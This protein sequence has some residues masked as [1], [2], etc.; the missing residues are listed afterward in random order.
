[1]EK[2]LLLW[3]VLNFVQK[4]QLAT[5][6]ILM[7]HSEGEVLILNYYYFL[8]FGHYGHIF[9][10]W[11]MILWGETKLGPILVALKRKR[12]FGS[13]D[14]HF[15]FGSVRTK[16]RAQLFPFRAHPPNCWS[17]S[18]SPLTMLLLLFLLL[19]IVRSGICI[20]FP[21]RLLPSV[22]IHKAHRGGEQFSRRKHVGLLSDLLAFN[23]RHGDRHA[24][25]LRW[26]LGASLRF[27][28][29]R[30]YLVLFPLHHYP[31]PCGH[32]DG[33]FLMSLVSCW[34]DS[35]DAVVCWIGRYFVIRHVDAFYMNLRIGFVRF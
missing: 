34:L 8:I 31:R 27:S 12:V 26:S 18:L 1:M 7:P 17:L 23:F 30:I 32:L 21:P 10:I 4:R 19:W 25:V 16:P 13:L 33:M 2:L 24:Q 3:L 15:F 20:A 14:H 5:R 35:S 9:I 11:F 29:R 6:N 22:S 28:Y